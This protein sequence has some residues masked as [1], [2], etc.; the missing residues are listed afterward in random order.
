MLSLSHLQSV[1]D[2]LNTL[3]DTAIEEGTYKTLYDDWGSNDRLDLLKVIYQSYVDRAKPSILK[4]TLKMLLLM[5]ML[6]SSILVHS[7]SGSLPVLNE[8]PTKL[9]RV[10]CCIILRACVKATVERTLHNILPKLQNMLLQRSRTD[11]WLVV[12]VLAVLSIAA[13]IH[14]SHFPVPQLSENEEGWSV[15]LGLY[16]AGYGGY[17]I[18]PTI[19][20]EE[21]S[22]ELVDKA[23]L[24]I[25]R[26]M[27]L[28]IEEEEKG[29]LPNTSNLQYLLS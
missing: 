4:D 17:R 15:L 16:T 19:S 22:S 25:S 3:A 27:H 7:I 1:Q 5:F 2:G 26:H 29:K 18:P 12:S 14:F 13:G 9:R 23:T 11:W 6:N 21:V 20:D 8:V 10:L 24:T 28:W